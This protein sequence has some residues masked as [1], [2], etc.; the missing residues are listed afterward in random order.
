MDEGESGGNSDAGPRVVPTETFLH[1]LSKDG[2]TYSLKPWKDIKNAKKE[3]ISKAL[4]EYM[5]QAWSE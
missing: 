2:Y 3:D 1:L 5:R 4:R